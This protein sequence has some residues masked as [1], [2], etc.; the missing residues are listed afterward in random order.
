MG[1]PY[2]KP[3]VPTPAFTNQKI[4]VGPHGRATGRRVFDAAIHPSQCDLSVLADTVHTGGGGLLH[5][6]NHSAGTPA[7]SL[8][9]CGNRAEW[10]A[11]D[12]AGGGDVAATVWAIHQRAAGSRSRWITTAAPWRVL[13]RWFCVDRRDAAAVRLLPCRAT[14]NIARGHQACAEYPLTC[15]SRAHRLSAKDLAEMTV[16]QLRRHIQNY[17]PQIAPALRTGNATKA[18]LLEDILKATEKTAGVK[19]AVAAATKEAA[20]DAAGSAK[21]SGGSD[22]SAG[23][24]RSTVSIVAAIAAVGAGVFYYLNPADDSNT[25]TAST[26]PPAPTTGRAESDR[27][28]ITEPSANTASSASASTSAKAGSESEYA[29]ALAVLDQRDKSL[30]AAGGADAAHAPAS[31]AGDE[32]AA[33]LAVLEKAITTSSA[34]ASTSAKAGSESEYAAALAVLDQ[35]DKSL[36]AAGGADAAHAPAST[37]GD[38]YAAA[39]AVLEK[40]IGGA[41]GGGADSGA[42]RS[43]EYAQALQV[44]SMP[45]FTDK[46]MAP[47]PALVAANPQQEQEHAMESGAGWTIGAALGALSASTPLRTKTPASPAPAA[48]TAVPASTAPASLPNSVVTGTGAVGIKLLWGRYGYRME[49]PSRIT[50]PALQSALC[51]RIGTTADPATRSRLRTPDAPQPSFVCLS[52]WHCAL[53]RSWWY[54]L[55]SRRI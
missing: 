16:P 20:K 19:E 29:A 8:L 32:Y 31:T 15:I 23:G 33:A 36:S 18:E 41:H 21:G 52:S 26:E 50:L 6:T 51:H 2:P 34:S 27:G 46:D 28:P 40:A 22:A 54:G 38:E 9:G 17:C 11:H 55:A 24:M 25:S 12:A 47:L 43:E 49:V 3:P 35:R 39:L 42:P 7:S 37:A 10:G 4:A 13:V 30:S 48:A 1:S 5:H 44:L 14:V 53:S 45:L